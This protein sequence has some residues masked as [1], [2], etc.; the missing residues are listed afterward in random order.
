MPPAVLGTNTAPASGSTRASRTPKRNAVVPTSPSPSTTSA[1]PASARSAEPNR[2][3]RVT[4]SSS[5]ITSNEGRPATPAAAPNDNST[6]DDWDDWAA[7]F[8]WDRVQHRFP[9]PDDTG[10][11]TAGTDT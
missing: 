1:T 11:T 7:P 10:S 9:D 8:S 2:P 3:R 5:R 6:D 4:P